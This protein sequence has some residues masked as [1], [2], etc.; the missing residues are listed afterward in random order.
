M[1]GSDYPHPDYDVLTVC[2]KRSHPNEGKDDSLMIIGVSVA[3]GLI[4]V[5][6]MII[7]CRIVNLICDNRVAH[8]DSKEDENNANGFIGD[9]VDIQWRKCEEQDHISE[10]AV[11]TIC[12]EINPFT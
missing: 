1:T 8:A 12:L 10:D 11:C 7:T 2:Q 3:S 6:F 4:F 5:G 9:A